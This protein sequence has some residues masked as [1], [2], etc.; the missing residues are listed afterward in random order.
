[1]MIARNLPHTPEGALRQTCGLLVLAPPPPDD[2][3]DA[4]SRARRRAPQK[5]ATRQRSRNMRSSR[6]GPMESTES[7]S[8]ITSAK[9]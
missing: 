8:R 4:A 1:M 3:R 6:A 9:W 2:G 7:T 5:K